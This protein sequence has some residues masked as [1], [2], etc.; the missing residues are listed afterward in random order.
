MRRS[1]GWEAL[2]DD[3]PDI[4]AWQFNRTYDQRSRTPNDP[5]Y[6]DQWY[7]ETIRMPEAWEFTTGEV[8]DS[9]PVPVV[10]VL[11]EGYTMDREDFED[12]FFVNPGEIHVN[13][14]HVDGNGLSAD[15]SCGVLYYLR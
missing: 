3:C 11:E 5:Q 7:L 8:P 15:V 14:M 6:K 4:Q 2:F 13:G 9:I 12:I 10:G 1:T